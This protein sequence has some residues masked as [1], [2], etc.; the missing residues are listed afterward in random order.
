[1]NQTRLNWVLRALALC[2]WC[3]AAPCDGAGLRVVVTIPPLK[4][5]IEPLLPEGSSVAVLM[6]PGRSEHNYEF[7]PS[8]MARV[9]GANLV[10]CVGLGLEQQLQQFLESHTS[11]KRVDLSLGAAAGVE[12]AADS[13]DQAS[14]GESEHHHGAVDPHVWLDPV[15]VEAALPRLADGVRDAMK[16]TGIW[17]DDAKKH[18]EDALAS[19][20]AEV[21]KLNLAFQEALAKFKGDKIV[22]HHA[23]FG[24][25]AN[26]YGLVVAEVI[27]VNEGEEPTPGRIAAIVQ[28]VRK[29]GVTAIYVEPQF[30]S[31]TAERIASAAGV[32]VV[33][34]DPLGNG[35]WIA[36]MQENLNGLV[37][38]LSKAK[39]K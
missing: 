7:T 26:R 9:G 12:Q 31:A 32:R 4:G 36:M 34:L 21:A 10:V 28:A 16:A 8:D 14:E 19:E 24:R 33:K 15:L 6:T 39:N 5:I 35:D 23:A 38:G 20:Q 3:L 13:D 22:T 17:N 25:L 18:L 2:V 30:S 27:R 1:M 37:A 29:E 11:P